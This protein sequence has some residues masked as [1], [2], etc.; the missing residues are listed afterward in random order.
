M[1]C[2]SI[3]IYLLFLYLIQI[4]NYS[5]TLLYVQKMTFIHNNTVY[6]N[7]VPQSKRYGFVEFKHHAHALACLRELNNARDCLQ[8]LPPLQR[9]MIESNPQTQTQQRTAERLI[10]EFSLENFSK[11]SSVSMYH[12]LEYLSSPMTNVIII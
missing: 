8:Y 9:Q 3:L 4:N 7:G 11:V 5:L 2:I 10:V 6:R 1:R 12:T